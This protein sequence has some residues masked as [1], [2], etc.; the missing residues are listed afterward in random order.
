MPSDVPKRIGK[1]CSETAPT[2]GPI[3]EPNVGITRTGSSIAKGAC[4]A[5]G[6]GSA[7]R[8][9]A[10]RKI[11]DSTEL[12]RPLRLLRPRPASPSLASAPGPAAA[13]VA[14]AGAAPSR[15]DAGAKSASAAAEGGAAPPAAVEATGAPASLTETGPDE[16]ASAAGIPADVG[17]KVRR[18]AWAAA[19]DEEALVA[20]AF[21]DTPSGGAASIA[22][23]PDAAGAV[24]AV[25]PGVAA[26]AAEAGTRMTNCAPPRPPLEPASTEGA[27]GL[28]LA[29]SIM[30]FVIAKAPAAVTA[31]MLRGPAG[32]PAPEGPPCDDLD[33]STIGAGAPGSGKSPARFA[34]K[35]A[36]ATAASAPTTPTAMA[37]PG[38]CSA[39]EVA[40]CAAPPTA[41][42]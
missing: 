12:V 23:A 39:A 2:S 38:V 24:G 25:A 30:G 10:M 16:A 11:T 36:A 29:A 40:C 18:C 42:F 17:S 26:A 22:G 13:G 5:L 9:T 32:P 31:S 41:A 7:S 1:W 27:A 19:E 6:C 34:K 14:M 37:Q 28:E 4:A 35:A 15:A 20:S 33:D 8:M 21:S 3:G